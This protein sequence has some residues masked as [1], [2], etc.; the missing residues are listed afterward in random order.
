MLTKFGRVRDTS[1]S[2]NKS[3]INVQQVAMLPEDM[4]DLG[5]IISS[6]SWNRKIKS[7][8][9]NISPPPTKIKWST[10]KCK[11]VSI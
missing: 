5:L 10:P 8:H 4:N 11:V 6:F 7:T 1:V 3:I 2:P 9:K